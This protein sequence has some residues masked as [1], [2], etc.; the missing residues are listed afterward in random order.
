MKNSGS[1]ELLRRDLPA[2]A[3]RDVRVV[4]VCLPTG[5]SGQGYRLTF[6]RR[7][8][9]PLEHIRRRCERTAM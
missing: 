2:H 8:A 5:Y 7:D 3:D 6:D 9:A 1:E 4:Q